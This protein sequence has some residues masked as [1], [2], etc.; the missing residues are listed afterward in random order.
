MYEEKYYKQFKK[1]LK[2]VKKQ[3]KN[4]NILRYVIDKLKQG[5]S[6]NP[7]YRD[8]FL[9]NNYK[10]C[11]ECHLD[12]NWLLIYKLDKNANILWLIGTGSHSELLEQLTFVEVAQ[13]LK[14]FLND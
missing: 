12:P 9:I 8:H 4:L 10:G 7:K 3:G 11:R 13:K 14:K 5:E 1:N 2:Q 6:L